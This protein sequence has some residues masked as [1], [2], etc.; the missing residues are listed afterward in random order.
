MTPITVRAHRD[1]GFEVLQG[2][3]TTEQL[4][5]GEMLETVVKMACPEVR[6]PRFGMKTQEAWD[7]RVPRMEGN[8]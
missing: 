2:E 8:Q 6:G 4:T 7:R 1:G 3:L 5:L